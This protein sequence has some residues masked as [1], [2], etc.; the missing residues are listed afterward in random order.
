MNRQEFEDFVAQTYNVAGERLWVRYPEY[1]VFRNPSSGKWFAC[2]MRIKKRLIGLGDGEIDV[3]NLKNDP[4]AI[5]FLLPT[6]GLFPAYHMNKTHWITAA[7]DGSVSDELIKALTCE[8]FDLTA[9][10]PSRKK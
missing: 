7:L 9:T 2:A 6:D 10:K 3:V 4:L 8:S 5:E 1:A